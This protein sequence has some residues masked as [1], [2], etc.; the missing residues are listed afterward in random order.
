MA[1]VKLDLSNPIDAEQSR[2]NTAMNSM[3]VMNVILVLAYLVEV[4]KGTRSILSYSIVVFLS[5]CPLILSFLRYQKKKNT[6]T[7]RYIGGIGFLLLYSYVMFTSTTDVTFCYVIILY[8]ILMVYADVKFSVIIGVYAF[9]VNVAVIMWRSITVGLTPTQITNAEIILA[10]ILL[11]TIFGITS[12]RKINLINTANLILAQE[13]KI[14][15]DT[16]LQTTLDVASQMTKDIDVVFGE[17]KILQEA[18]DVTKQAMDNLNDGTTQ[19]AYAIEEQRQDTEEISRY[20]QEVKNATEVMAGAM[21]ES[22]EVLAEGKNVMKHLQQQVSNSEGNSITVAKEMEELKSYADQMQMVMKLISNVAYQTGLLALNA[23]I[24]AA[25][26]GEAGRGFSVVATEISSLASQTST[27]TGDI[28]TLIESITGS[29]ARVAAAVDELL[30]SNKLQNQYVGEVA[31]SYR[32]LE[33]HTT[34]IADQSEKLQTK[35]MAVSRA[36]EEII[37]QIENISSIT[38]EVTAS[39]EETLGIC[40]ENVDSISHVMKVMD[41]LS[42]QAKILA[43]NEMDENSK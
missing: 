23:S 10:C 43:A 39:A 41:S 35:V 13:E 34:E 24:E 37:E 5:L 11:S 15:A 42:G 26:A 21:E 32:S 38:E 17:S 25:R 20:I 36:N 7:V 29:V 40:S 16:L 19:A 33:Q 30:E 1:K 18:M 4:F 6:R 31:E 9:L 3:T 2:N 22:Q 28:D 8:I 14:T 27:A 12:V